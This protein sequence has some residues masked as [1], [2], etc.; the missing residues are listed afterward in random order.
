MRLSFGKKF[1]VG[2]IRTTRQAEVQ[3][4]KVDLC[5]SQYLS[6]FDLGSDLTNEL[7]TNLPTLWR[8]KPLVFGSLL[9]EGVSCQFLVPG[10]EL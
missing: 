7:P 1:E 2:M 10:S 3:G 6:P 9:F 8:E 4:S 5:S